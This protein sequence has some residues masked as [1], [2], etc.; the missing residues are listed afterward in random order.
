MVIRQ[1]K[2]SNLTKAA[3]KTTTL[4]SMQNNIKYAMNKA[5]KRNFIVPGANA[6]DVTLQTTEFTGNFVAG[7]EI[8][9][10]PKN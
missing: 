6:E 2:T 7:C 3:G 5:A 10:R 1:R 8:R 9:Y 4:A